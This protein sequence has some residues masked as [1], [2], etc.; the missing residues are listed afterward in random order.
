MLRKATLQ[1]IVGLDT[2]SL[3]NHAFYQYE[4]LSK[5]AHTS[6]QAE[7]DDAVLDMGEG[8]FED[9]FCDIEPPFHDA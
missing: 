7:N 4:V 8:D 3:V 1:I 5:V 9:E 2:Q 6:Y